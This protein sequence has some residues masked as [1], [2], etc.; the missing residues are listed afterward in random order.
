MVPTMG[1]V[2]RTAAEASSAETLPGLC[3]ACGKDVSRGWR[4]RDREGNRRCKRCHQRWRHSER[5]PLFLAAASVRLRARVMD[6]LF[7]VVSFSLV[8]ALT[9]ALM[10]LRGEL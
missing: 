2:V 10:R 5:P 3:F 1:A 6:V 4:S 9:Y 7:Y 8:G